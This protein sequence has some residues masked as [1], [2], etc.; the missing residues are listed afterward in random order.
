MDFGKIPHNIIWHA[1][2]VAFYSEWS[3]QMTVIYKSN[4]SV[5]GWHKWTWTYYVTQLDTEV[6]QAWIWC[7]R[8]WIIIRST[9]LWLKNNWVGWD[10]KWLTHITHLWYICFFLSFFC[11]SVD[12]TKNQEGIYGSITSS[13]LMGFLCK[14]ICNLHI[15]HENYKLQQSSTIRSYFIP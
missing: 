4:L 12:H 5:G 10:H 6:R 3:V 9:Y 13:C 11:K 1:P 14:N 8:V 15:G 7:K 2:S